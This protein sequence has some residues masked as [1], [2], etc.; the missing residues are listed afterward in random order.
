MSVFLALDW[1]LNWREK[2]KG[3]MMGGAWEV[4]G[5]AFSML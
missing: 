1:S 4:Q 5:G 3:S 2:M